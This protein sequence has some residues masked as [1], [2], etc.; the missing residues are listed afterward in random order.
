M[1]KQQTEPIKAIT[2]WQPWATLI[3]LGAK[4]FETRSWAITY[5]GPLVIHASK[6]LTSAEVAYMRSNPF[7][8]VLAAGGYHHPA[9][10]P[11]GK[12]ICVVD[13][14]GCLTSVEAFLIIS[15]Q[16]RAFGNYQPD[17]FAWKLA[18]VRRFARPI[19]IQGS[20]GL[21]NWPASIP[22]PEVDHG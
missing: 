19:P 6:R 11:L 5:R 15:D 2:L 17:R 16:E 20:Q 10:L 1:N 9:E 3:A 4:S 14:V 18:N 8:Q 12:A 21:W 7:R 22:L 13:V